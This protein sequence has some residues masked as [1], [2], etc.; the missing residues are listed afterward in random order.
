MRDPRLRVIWPLAASLAWPAAT[1]RATN[2]ATDPAQPAPD[3]APPSASSPV[4]AAAK[5]AAAASGAAAAPPLEP[6]P[7]AFID[8]PPTMPRGMMA[9]ALTS[10][11]AWAPEPRDRSTFGVGLALA[12]HDRVELGAGLPSAR[13]WDHDPD[14]CRGRSPLDGTY[15]SLAF[16]LRR[17]GDSSWQAGV[18][19]SIE[20]ADAPTE[21][22]SRVWLTGKRVWFRRLAFYGTG[23]LAIGWEHPGSFTGAAAPTQTNQTRIS[24]TE[25]ILWQVVQRVSIF[26][27]GNPYRPLGVPGNESW[28][29]AVGGGAI[30]AFDR[31]WQ[32]AF[33]CRVENV[34]PARA[35]QYVPDGK[36]CG[37]AFT[38]R[39]LPR[40][41]PPP[42]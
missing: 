25:T 4:G 11:S 21:Y 23:E 35:W 16:G 13:C 9:G 7:L 36:D 15:L 24:W 12:L 10:D 18:A 31:Q 32:L 8:R 42:Q 1:A 28:A 41:P 40:S 22:R 29:T 3:A 33:D 39:Y 26:A 2:G 14:S 37:V 30:W 5:P 34:M 6:W 19:G 17:T 20:R 27:Y 38:F